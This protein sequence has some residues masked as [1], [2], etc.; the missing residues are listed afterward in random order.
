MQRNRLSALH[1]TLQRLSV[2]GRPAIVAGMLVM[3]LGPNPIVAAEVEIGG[4]FTLTDQN[5]RT[6]SDEDFRGAYMLINFGYTYCPDLCPTSLMKMTD[7]I[8]ALEKRDTAKAGQIVPIFITVDPERDTPEVLKQYAA[9]FSPRL[10][11]LS[12]SAEALRNV[13]YPYGVFYGKVP[14]GSGGYLMDHT[15]F[16]YLMGPDGRYI[17]HFESDVTTDDLVLTLGKRVELPAS[18]R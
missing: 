3:L 8:A 4:P 13:A 2:L 6:R 9:N 12:G 14:T 1:P 7:A 16:I 5:G 11:A 10:V 17:T 18:Q 15:G